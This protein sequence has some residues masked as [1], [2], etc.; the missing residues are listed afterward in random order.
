MRGATRA[1]LGRRFGVPGDGDAISTVVA[2]AT[3]L[4]SQRVED[5][6]AGPE[7]RTDEELIRL[8]SLLSEIEARSMRTAGPPPSATTGNG[9]PDTRGARL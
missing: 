4:P 9:G 6:L 3:G 2:N 8:G 1:R 7:P 5:G